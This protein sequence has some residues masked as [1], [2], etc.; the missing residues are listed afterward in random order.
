MTLPKQAQHKRLQSDRLQFNHPQ[1]NHSQ[2]NTSTTA[3]AIARPTHQRLPNKRLIVCC[4]GT[5]NEPSESP[6]KQSPTNVFKLSQAIPARD[7]QG[8]PQL[9]SY[10]RGLGTGGGISRLSGGSVGAGID[11]AIQDAY[12]FLSMNYQPGDEIYLFGFSRGAYTVRSL[13][14]FIY[15]AGL[16]KPEDISGDASQSEIDRIAI[17]NR[18]EEA[19]QLYRSRNIKPTSDRAVAFRDRDT[20]NFG[21]VP[22]QL[23]CCWDTVSALGIPDFVPL[24]PLGDWLNQRYRFHDYKLCA[25]IKHALHAVALDEKRPSFNVTPME[26]REGQDT[27]L[28]QVLFPGDHGCVG[29]GTKATRRL[30]NGALQWV[31]DRIEALPELGLEIDVHKMGETVVHGNRLDTNPLAPIEKHQTWKTRLLWWTLGRFSPQFRRQVPALS[32]AAIAWLNDYL[33]QTQAVAPSSG[34]KYQ[35]ERPVL[36]RLQ[37]LAQAHPHPQGKT[38]ATYDLHDSTKVRL[39]NEQLCYRPEPLGNFLRLNSSF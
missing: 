12:L 32:P 33:K 7:R 21:Q 16:L 18:L 19:Y 30:A 29:G 4:D 35:P 5:W 20:A 31:L 37:H 1:A 36:Q 9:V 27:H 38:Q 15:L 13:A 23:L 22:I 10:F 6:I 2:A 24:G 25:K 28:E 26:V 8:V 3:E 34:L 14:G 17:A 39:M 11:Q